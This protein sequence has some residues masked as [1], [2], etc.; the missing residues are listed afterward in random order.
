M[1]IYP[2]GPI[3]VMGDWL[4]Y[5][6]SIKGIE[7]EWKDTDY[8]YFDLYSS[9]FKRD[10]AWYYRLTRED[11]NRTNTNLREFLNPVHEVLGK[12]P[13]FQFLLQYRPP[14]LPEIA[15]IKLALQD[16]IRDPKQLRDLIS[17]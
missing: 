15:S 3:F 16:R 17:H 10:D 11:L 13:D 14:F 12:N 4:D 1:I 5:P 9:Y 8:L 2:G 7:E 6:T